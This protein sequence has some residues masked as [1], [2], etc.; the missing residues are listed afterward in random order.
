MEDSIRKLAKSTYWQNV[1]ANAKELGV[2]SLFNN[3]T[4]LTKIQIFFL[5]WLSIYNSLYQDLVNEEDYINEDVIDD[6]IRTDAYLLWKRKMKD[7]KNT[8]KEDN[9]DNSLGIPRVEFKSSRKKK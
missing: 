7:K 2:L 5:H 1:Y 4:K 9:T 8:K 6:E 3:K